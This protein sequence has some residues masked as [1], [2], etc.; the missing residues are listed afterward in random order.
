[1]SISADLGPTQAA[2]TK[3]APGLADPAE[4]ERDRGLELRPE[5]ASSWQRS[6]S[7][8]LAP[9]RLIVPEH[10]PELESKFVR[11]ARPVLRRISAD[12]AA[13]DVSVVLSDASANVLVRA[14]GSRSIRARLDQVS[15]GPGYAYAEE[16]V[17]TNAIGTALA[18]GSPALIMGREHFAEVLTE[19]SCA[20]APIVDPV[21]CQVV[22]VIDLT[23]AADDASPLMLGLAR[24]GAREI[25]Q[26]M[27]ALM[28]LVYQSMPSQWKGWQ[29][30][31]S[32]EREIAELVSTGLTNK[33]IA[34]T[35]YCSP[36]TVDSHLRAVY[37]KLGITSRAA[38]AGHVTRLNEA[39]QTG[40]ER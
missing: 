28:P 9:D 2:A 21:N 40:S 24:S 37:R 12:L 11:A 16:T 26:R 13:L 3:P 39:A 8:G 10:E 33:Q 29:L 5:I 35:L 6:A 31:T 38:L 1:M 17:G 36:Y 4:L 18:M 30:L 25:E 22:G 32:A 20:A 14:D 15:L 7:W 19:L 23:S 34:A 27:M